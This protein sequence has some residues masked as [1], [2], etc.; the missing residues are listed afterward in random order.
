LRNRPAVSNDPFS[1]ILRLTEA[2]SV[3]SGGFTAGGTWALRFPVPEKMKFFALAKGA[4]W[5][6]VD[7]QKRAVTL[8]QGDVFLVS[9]RNGFLLASSLATPPRDARRVFGAEG[10][11]FVHLGGG[12]D[13][14]FIGGHVSLHPSSRDLLTDV[15]PALVLVRAASA[16]AAMLRWILEHLVQERSS[17]LPGPN[18]VCAQLAQ[19]LFV[20]V[21]RAHLASSGT[22]PSGW[23]RAI[24]DDRIAPALRLM[25]GDPRRAWTLNELAKATAMSRSSFA[26]R[27][28]SVAGVAPLS[29]LTEWRMRLA[30][31]VLRDEDT[32]VF[33]L[34]DS[35]GYASESAFSN[36][37]KRVTGT[38]PR[39]Y[40]KA[41]RQLEPAV[42]E[43][44]DLEIGPRVAIERGVARSIPR[45]EIDE[46]AQRPRSGTG[47][48]HRSPRW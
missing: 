13:C 10:G 44:V 38:S 7:G 35:L 3:V 17:T 45:R 27:F 20:Q 6:R 31:R 14:I 32:S 37:F 5:L 8:D 33:E 29:Y 12:S 46:R 47:R 23:L 11:T 34:G 43:A 24:G 39:N 19:L 25:H 18:T 48:P 40:R 26:E 1:D 4:C 15:L 22:L 41:A 16:Q 36:A 9:G 28:K 2:K 30:Q 42:V 21:L